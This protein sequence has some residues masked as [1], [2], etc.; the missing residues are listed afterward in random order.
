MSLT[1]WLTMYVVIGLLRAVARPLLPGLPVKW[2]IIVFSW[3]VIAWPLY[4]AT[5]IAAL[6]K[7]W[8]EP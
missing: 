2:R 4:L 8:R 7:A 1:F 3:R 5:V 6:V